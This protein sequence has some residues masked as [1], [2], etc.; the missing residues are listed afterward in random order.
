MMSRFRRGRRIRQPALLTAL[1]GSQGG[2][3]QREKREKK[4]EDVTAGIG[5]DDFLQRSL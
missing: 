1:P 4:R 2:Q 5:K 3:A